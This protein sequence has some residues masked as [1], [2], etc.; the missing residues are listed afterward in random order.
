MV[1][2]RKKFLFCSFPCVSLKNNY[3]C[4]DLQPKEEFAYVAFPRRLTH[5]FGSLPPP[6]LA[7][8]SSKTNAGYQERFV[9]LAVRLVQTYVGYA[10]TFPS[11]EHA[12]ITAN[13]TEATAGET[14]TLTV[15]PDAHYVLKTITVL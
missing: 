5:V 2:G 12:T 10:V 9:G 14:I 6:R 15:S 4:S 3:L 11:L 1:Y 13:K 8:R 7:F